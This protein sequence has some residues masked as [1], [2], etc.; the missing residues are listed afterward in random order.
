MKNILV[1][2]T[3]FPRWKNDTE[4]G[5]FVYFLSKTLA[6]RGYKVSIFA[7][8]FLGA[9]M[10]EKMDSLDVFRFIYFYPIKLQK[11]CYDGGILSNLKRSFFIRFEIPFFFFF[12]LIG[13]IKLVKR[14]KINV[15]HAH[16][17]IPQGLIAFV[18]K[19]LYNIPYIV[20]AHAGDIFPLKNRFLRLLSKFVL[21]NCDYCTVNSNATK[22]VVLEVYN[23]KNIKVIPM[24]VDLNSFDKSRRDNSLR[25]KLDIDGEF[26]LSVGR[27]AD[28]KGVKY[29]IRAMPLVLKSF[30]RAKLIIVGDGPERGNLE[31]L[32][33]ELDLRD[34]IKFIGRIPNKNLPKY[35]ATADV[36][37]GP[38]IVT[39]S[40]DTEGLGVVFLEAIASGIPVIGSNVGGIPDIIKNKKTGILVEQKNSLQIARA[41]IKLLNDKKLVFKLVKNGQ[42]HIKSNYSWIIVADKFERLYRDLTRG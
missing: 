32:T 28:K 33:D 16:W 17:I 31:K 11:L 24:G 37:V 34:N 5:F 39:K 19:K 26:I 12:D 15:I 42:R 10:Y 9:E 14:K 40:G 36:F 30:L 20:T 7:P 22:D 18:I 4:P 1:T 25:R 6:E 21:M 35:Y 8:H 41:I 38:S 23:V 13:T 29:L 27:L 3:N 2:T